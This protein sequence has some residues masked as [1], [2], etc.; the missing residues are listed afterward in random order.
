L[1]LVIYDGR[2]G[3]TLS[4]TF[5]PPGARPIAR[6]GIASGA[7]LPATTAW[8]PWI[9][10]VPIQATG[11][12]FSQPVVGVKAAIDTSSAGFTRTPCYFAWLAG[13]LFNPNTGQLLP[14]MFS[15]LTDESASGFTFQMWFPP[16]N[17]VIIE[18]ANVTAAA[19]AATGVQVIREAEDFFPF[20]RQ[21][22][23]YVQWIA[24]QMPPAVPYV[25]L[26]LR[27]LNEWLLPLVLQ[28]VET[29][30]NLIK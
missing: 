22:K 12:F 13:P 20:A 27:I 5:V 28:K 4:P 9:I 18:V 24:C 8:E 15:S 26:R 6:P 2:G 1:G 21:Q 10:D 11:A 17:E 23:L 30:R 16:A 7:T 3:R 19:P 14:D 25:P 29:V